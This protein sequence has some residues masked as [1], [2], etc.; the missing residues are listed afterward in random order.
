M[1]PIADLQLSELQPIADMQIADMLADLLAELQ[2]A[3]PEF[4]DSQLANS[5]FADSQLADR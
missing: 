2:L 5:E 3:N 4:A 1:L